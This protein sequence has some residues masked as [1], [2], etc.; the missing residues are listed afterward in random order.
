[1]S[2]FHNP[3]PVSKKYT[4]P[5]LSTAIPEPGCAKTEVKRRDVTI[6]TFEIAGTFAP[7]AMPGAAKQDPKTGWKQIAAYIETPSGTWTVKFV[8]PEKSVEKFKEAFLKWLKS[9]KLGEKKTEKD[10]DKT[11]E[12]KK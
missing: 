6:K 5:S 10:K 8:G 9:A 2:I 11:D 4:C 1:M 3:D 12:P 7:G